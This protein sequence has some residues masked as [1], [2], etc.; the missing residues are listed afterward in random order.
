MVIEREQLILQLEMIKNQQFQLDEEND[1]AYFLPSML[2]YIGDEDPYLRDELIYETFSH[3]IL[4]LDYLEEEECIRIFDQVISKEFLLNHSENGRELLVL[5]RS[6]SALVLA[7]LLEKNLEMPYLETGRLKEGA[8]AVLKAIQT[9]EDYRGYSKQVGWIHA[10]AH[11][12]DCVGMLLRHE[13]LK[14]AYGPLFIE[15]IQGLFMR[16][17]MVLGAAEDERLVTA[18]YDFLFGGE[19]H[20]ENGLEEWLKGFSIYKKEQVNLD[21]VSISYLE[22]V[23]RTNKKQFIRSLYFRGLKRGL[24]E[25]WLKKMFEVERQLSRYE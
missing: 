1:V 3:W 10:I 15:A 2:Y 12:G 24:S 22:S 17:N 9:E 19:N 6:F 18:V 21:D 16:A 11:Y 4:A 8:E 25:K 7:C 23:I 5:K 14:K 20:D 13:I